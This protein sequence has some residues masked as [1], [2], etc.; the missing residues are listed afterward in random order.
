MS[1]ASM[2]IALVAGIAAACGADEGPPVEFIPPAE[3]EPVAFDEIG[4]TSLLFE[5][6]TATSLALFLIDGSAR[7]SRIAYD[8]D[9]GIMRGAAI[10][11]TGQ[12]V[13]FTR[14]VTDNMSFDL[15]VIGING[16]GLV[17]LTN[18]PEF[19]GVPTWTRDG[20]SII[21]PL[22]LG[23]FR[24]SVG[25]AGAEQVFTTRLGP[26][27]TIVCPH[28]EMG[29]PAMLS[30]RSELALAC[31]SAVYKT[32]ADKQTTVTLYEM[33]NSSLYA[34][35]WSSDGRTVAFI[36]V[37]PGTLAVRSLRDDENTS[38]LL[39]TVPSGKQSG[40][41]E[42]GMYSLCWSADNARLFFSVPESNGDAH[43]WTVRADGTGLRQITSRA[44]AFD[45]NVSC[46][47]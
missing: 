39:A 32:L 9:E 22:S 16:T 31:R 37:R 15:F 2:I 5:R 27:Q 41:L 6:A 35:A 36:E 3:L 10:S 24:R 38:R 12:R 46:A 44:G 14:P 23:Y 13:V 45:F 1:K 26:G 4:T 11:P 28:A 30:V 40:R 29:M 19:E 42:W 17:R 7:T 20:F 25:G 43:I 47:G 18:T 21:Y 8:F 34:P 33:E